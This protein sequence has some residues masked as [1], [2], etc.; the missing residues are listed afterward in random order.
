VSFAGSYLRQLGGWIA[1]ADLIRCLDQLGLTESSVRQALVRL[2]SRG[3]LAAERRSGEAGYLLTDAGL[4][5]LTTGDRRIFRP[6]TAT[7]ED[8]WVLAVFSVPEE[9]RHLRHQL[10]AELSWLGFGTVSPGVWIAPRPLADPTRALLAE[11]GLDEY[12]TWFAAQHL[13][14]IDVATWWDLDS[15]RAQYETFL[16]DHRP[17]TAVGSSESAFPDEHA[18]A[19]YLRLID[20]WRLFPRLDP[21]LPEPLLPTGWPARSAWELF[22][23]LRAAWS[24][25]GLRYVRAVTKR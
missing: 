2:K 7:T 8:G 13:T 14:E 15:L 12:V 21:G 11:A 20:D 23:Q 5:D 9:Q 16:A 10:R 4:R 19:G 24:E 25:P 1:V 6:A 18:F 22:D 17:A 3:F